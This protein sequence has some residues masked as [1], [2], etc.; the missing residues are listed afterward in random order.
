MANKIMKY[1]FG[2]PLGNGV[3]NFYY[4][5]PPT[6]PDETRVY[7]FEMMNGSVKIGMSGDVGAR[8]ASVERAVLTSVMRVHKTN[9]AP[10]TFIRKLEAHCHAV[11]AA[12][13][14]RGEFFNITFE[15]AV[16]ELDKHVAAITQAHDEAERDYQRKAALYTEKHAA[17]E[18]LKKLVETEADKLLVRLNLSGLSLAVTE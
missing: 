13:R 5:K 9:P 15:E 14:L 4:L 12:R 3:F 7:A 11:F 10:S 8:A 16:A 18:R 2:E 6:R 17:I 1:V